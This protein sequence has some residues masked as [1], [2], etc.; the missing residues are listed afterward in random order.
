MTTKTTANYAEARDIYKG[1]WDEHGTT[2]VHLPRRIAIQILTEAGWTPIMSSKVEDRIDG[3]VDPNGDWRSWHTDE[4]L[5][6]ELA[7]QA[8]KGGE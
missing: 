6:V 7:A 2:S 3:W 1:E 5:Q 8:L 4:A